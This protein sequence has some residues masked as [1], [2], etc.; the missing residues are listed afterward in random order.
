MS[1][2]LSQPVSIHL[3]ESLLSQPVSIHLNQLKKP[4]EPTK[5]NELNKPKQLVNVLS[6]QTLLC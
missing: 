4:N 1:L 5:L 6:F 2:R 3:N